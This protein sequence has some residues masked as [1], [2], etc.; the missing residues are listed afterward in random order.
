MWIFE[1]LYKIIVDFIQK[2]T[3]NEITF[4][5]EEECNHVFLPIDST[6]KILACSKCGILIKAE[7]LKPQKPQNVF[8]NPNF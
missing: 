3:K 1:I 5:E 6:K 2:R 7:N 4:L 8:D